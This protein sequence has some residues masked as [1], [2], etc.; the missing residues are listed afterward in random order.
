[1]RKEFLLLSL[2]ACGLKMNI[3]GKTHTLG[4]SQETAQAPTPAPTRTT[5]S[6]NRMR[7]NRPRTSRP[8]RS[9]CTRR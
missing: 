8:R 1:M 9:R 6:S 2:A 4:G 7:R 5:A 3:N